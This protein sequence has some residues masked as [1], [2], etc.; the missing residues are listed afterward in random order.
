MG[1]RALALCKA[2]GGVPEENHSRR[3][4]ESSRSCLEVAELLVL[5]AGVTAAE[6]SPAAGSPLGQCLGFGWAVSLTPVHDDLLRAPSGKSCDIS[7]LWWSEPE[8]Q[9]LPRRGAPEL[10]TR[11]MFENEHHRVQDPE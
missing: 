7:C 10:G 11:V 8:T 6:E 4:L 1:G 3:V 9:G 2:K 5:G